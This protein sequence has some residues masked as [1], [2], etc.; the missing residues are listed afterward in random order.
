MID[1]A[2]FLSFTALGTPRLPTYAL[3]R[4]FLMP[5]AGHYDTGLLSRFHF[6][7]HVA[8]SV[9]GVAWDSWRAASTGGA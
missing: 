3:C 5:V 4:R 2:R 1:V 8:S 9:A 6:A 7:S